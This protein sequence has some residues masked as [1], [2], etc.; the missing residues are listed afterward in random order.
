MRDADRNWQLKL[1]EA[2]RDALDKCEGM[3]K[4]FAKENMRERFKHH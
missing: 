3:T 4:Y 1:V 2:W